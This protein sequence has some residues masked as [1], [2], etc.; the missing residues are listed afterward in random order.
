MIDHEIA[1]LGRRMGMPGLTFPSS[2]IIALDV[3]GD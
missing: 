3:E 1:E 2:G